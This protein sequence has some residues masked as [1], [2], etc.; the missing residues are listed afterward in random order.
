M[1]AKVRTR[2]LPKPAE[3]NDTIIEI[4]ENMKSGLLEPSLSL[5]GRCMHLPD[6][7]CEVI[8]DFA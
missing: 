7:G 1:R 5:S 4:I 2:L 8:R 3:L 6:V